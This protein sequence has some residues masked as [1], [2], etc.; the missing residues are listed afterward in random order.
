MHL[1]RLPGRHYFLL[2][3][4]QFEFNSFMAAKGFSLPALK[5]L[6]ITLRPANS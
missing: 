2:P 1:W 6:I 3:Q 5:T 4:C